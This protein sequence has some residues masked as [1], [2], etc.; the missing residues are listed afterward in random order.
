MFQVGYEFES[1]C[2]FTGGSHSYKVVSR[3][4]KELKCEAEYCE[5]DG[6]H[7]VKESFNVYKED[8]REYIVLWTYKGEEGRHYEPIEDDV[9]EIYEEYDPCE[10]CQRMS[11][12]NCKH[13][14]YGDDGNYSVYDVYTP[15]ELGIRCKF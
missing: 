1:T 12:Y 4:E 7:K 9:E 2:I 6:V 10:G 11:G 14:Q 5:I 15:A 8:G 3:T 13:C